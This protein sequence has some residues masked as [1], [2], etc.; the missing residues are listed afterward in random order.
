MRMQEICEQIQEDLMCFLDGMDQEVIDNA[1]QI[2]VDNF[3]KQDTVS[4]AQL[5][6]EIGFS[7]IKVAKDTSE[8]EAGRLMTLLEDQRDEHVIT[9]DIYSGHLVRKMIG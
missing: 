8:K 3:K 7:E 4:F 1:C 6:T 5:T 9:C 2:V